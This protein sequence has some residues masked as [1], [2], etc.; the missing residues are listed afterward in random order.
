MEISAARTEYD[1]VYEYGPLYRDGPD[2]WVGVRH[3]WEDDEDHVDAAD[4]VADGVVAYRLGEDD[5]FHPDFI[6]I[7]GLGVPDKTDRQPHVDTLVSVICG[8][9]EVWDGWTAGW[10]DERLLGP[11]HSTRGTAAATFVTAFDA[12]LYLAGAV[13]NHLRVLEYRRTVVASELGRA[14]ILDGAAGDAG[15]R[16]AA[17]IRARV[18]SGELITSA[19]DTVARG[20]ANVSRAEHKLADAVRRWLAAEWPVVCRTVP[21]DIFADML[22]DAGFDY[23]KPDPLA[24]W[25]PAVDTP[26]LAGYVLKT[27]P[28]APP[29]ADWDGPLRV[30]DA[31]HF[32]SIISRYSVLTEKEIPAAPLQKRQP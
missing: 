19:D 23:S 11:V 20:A 2:V 28:A 17:D 10:S 7:R 25:D 24:A 5:R 14:D 32:C 4:V 29:G 31:D 15:K 26:H 3:H 30:I 18:A 8:D 27:Y 6:F 13:Q 9:Q 16:L 21:P 12:K 1:A 22:R